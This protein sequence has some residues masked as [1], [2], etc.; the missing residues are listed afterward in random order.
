[1]PDEQELTPEDTTS[2]TLEEGSVSA[3]EA[4]YELNEIE[5]GEDATE[6]TGT[7]DDASGEEDATE[8]TGTEDDASGEEKSDPKGFTKRINKKHSELMA[9]KQRADALQQQI[10]ALKQEQQPSVRPEIPPVPDAF[11]ENFAAKI[12]ARDLAIQSAV[13]HDSRQEFLAQQ[14][15][16]AAENKQ[17]ADLQ[18][19]KSTV[20]TYA[21]RAEKLGINAEELNVAGQTVAAMGI[22]DEVTLHILTDEKG[23]AITRFLAHNPAEIDKIN[24]LLPMA[25][26]VYIEKNIVSR[27]SPTQAR[28][29]PPKPA[30]TLG[31]GGAPRKVRGPDGVTYS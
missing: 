8:E 14:E 17:N 6:E 23:P 1:M 3:A 19:L 21:E 22:S 29:L 13:A 25:A 10:N 16:I 15:R 24:T 2:E 27:L 5:E 26:A 11:D 28:K 18:A 12:E 9:E 4:E 20:S 30:D 7:E 31:K